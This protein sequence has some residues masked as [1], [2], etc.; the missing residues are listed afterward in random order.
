MNKIIEIQNNQHLTQ[1]KESS[2][3]CVIDCYAD[4]CGPC[5]R[6][7][8]AYK[9]LSEK[10]E[11]QAVEFYKLKIDLNEPD[12]QEFVEKVQVEYIPLFLIYENGELIKKVDG[13][14]ELEEIIEDKLS[15]D[16]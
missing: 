6:V 10:F 8:P 13:I 7:F 16:L 2:N 15:V 11:E 12:V 4:W 14:S 3:L 1:L 9:A 5:K